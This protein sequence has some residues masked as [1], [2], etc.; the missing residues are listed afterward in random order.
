MGINTKLSLDSV[1]HHLQTDYGFLP[2]FL[3]VKPG[4]A[5]IE[6]ASM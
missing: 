1:V 2:E 5:G 3:C 4:N 6:N